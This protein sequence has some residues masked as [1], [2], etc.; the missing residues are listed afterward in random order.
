M[1]VAREVPGPGQES[2][3]DYPRP[4]RVEVSDE[5]VQI[6][7]GGGVVARSTRSLRVLE[8]SHPPT[9]YVPEADFAPGTLRP[10]QGSTR[11]EF[12]GDAA[13]FDVVGADGSVARSAAWT[14]PSPM[15][16]F[17]ALVGHVAVMPGAM[18]ECRVDDEVVTPQQGGFY[19]GWI[20]SRVVGPFKGAPGTWG[21]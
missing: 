13:Y 9:Y 3:W 15:P 14:Y 4:P 21:W 16:G 1:T 6:R 19:G 12:K 17:E 8:T 20:T 5:V 10:A 11:C 7:F 2:V 18:D